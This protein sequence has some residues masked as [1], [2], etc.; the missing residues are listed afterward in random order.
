MKYY[1]I[2]VDGTSDQYLVKA[3]NKKKSKERIG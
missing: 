1:L 2:E 3:N